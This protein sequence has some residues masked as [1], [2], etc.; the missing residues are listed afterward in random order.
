MSVQKNWSFQ[1]IPNLSGRVAIVTGANSGIGFEM[2]RALA[3]KGAEVIMACRSMQRGEDALQKIL[4]EQP[5]ANITLIQLDLADLSSVRRFVEVFKQRA[6]AL[7]ILINNAGVMGIPKRQ[8]TADGFEMQFGT[9]HLGHFA[10]SGLL[11][12]IILKTPSARMVTVSSF[13]HRTARIDF[14]NLNGG[15]TYRS[16]RSYG[17]SKLANLLF[18]LELQRHF[19]AF[20]S[21]VLSVGAH[22]GWTAT[23]LQ[24]YTGV[25]R[26]LNPFFGQSPQMG[27]LPT[28]YAATAPGVQGGSY[29]GPDRFFENRGHPAEAHLSAKARDAQTAAQLWQVSENLTG[30]RFRFD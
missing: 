2:S 27:A 5:G 8:E 9:N 12:E 28:L 4:E 19:D 24:R 25:L 17:Q 18:M 15:R 23:N 30:V 10:L 20:A 11:M 7:H 14:D 1:D 29:F 22:P 13:V 3:G 26:F 21:H 6:R 16:M